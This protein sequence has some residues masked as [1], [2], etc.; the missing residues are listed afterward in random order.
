M[1]TEVIL[2]IIVYSV[3]AILCLVGLVARHSGKEIFTKKLLAYTLGII[4][5]AGG[6]GAIMFRVGSLVLAFYLIEAL[7]LMLGIV[8][9]VLS[10]KLFSFLPTG[11]FWSELL[12]AAFA[13]LLIGASFSAMFGWLTPSGLPASLLVTGLVPFLIPV[14]VLYALYAWNAIP[15]KIYKKWFYPVERPVPLVELDNTLRLNFLVTKRP[16]AP[17]S[18][19]FTVTLPADRTLD[20]LFQF[21]I[22]SHN[23]EEDPEH[24]ILYHEDNTEGTL[25]GWI[26]YRESWGGW[27][28][29]YFDPS[30]SLLRNGL[31]PEDTIIARSFSN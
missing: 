16:D 7:A 15:L 4:A 14:L 13:V 30:L 28:K 24:P 29:T 5:V 2:P 3:V 8:H 17:V 25:L 6:L 21:M 10:R 22:Y 1:K 19:R 27:V 26:F 31:K 12:L 18:N 11:G 20:E 23:H 9:V